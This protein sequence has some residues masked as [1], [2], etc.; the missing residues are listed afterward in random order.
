MPF[1]RALR[2]QVHVDA[3]RA[4]VDDDEK[5]FCTVKLLCCVAHAPD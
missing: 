1:R 3:L 5:S 2:E 4:G